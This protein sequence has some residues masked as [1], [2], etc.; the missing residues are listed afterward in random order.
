MQVGIEVIAQG[1]GT[2]GHLR[3]EF[4]EVNVSF[5]SDRDAREGKSRLLFSLLFRVPGSDTWDGR[6]FASTTAR[7]EFLDEWF[8]DQEPADG[9]PPPSPNE[10]YLPQQTCGHALTSVVFIHDY[11]QLI[12]DAWTLNVYSNAR[13]ENGS[14]SFE[15]GQPG[16]CDELVTLIGKHIEAFEEQFGEFLEIRF[17]GGS[18]LIIPWDESLVE[19]ATLFFNGALVVWP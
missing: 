6:R 3:Y 12:S 15:R 14:A 1:L 4:Q 11:V 19:F 16:Y 7:R 2:W 9:L 17:S 13:L 8:L 5:A 18:R 10:F